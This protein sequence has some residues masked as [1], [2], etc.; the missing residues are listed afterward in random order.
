VVLVAGGVRK[1]GGEES[2]RMTRTVEEDCVADC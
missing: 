2:E 1:R